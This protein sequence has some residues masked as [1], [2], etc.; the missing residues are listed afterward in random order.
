MSGLYNQGSIQGE[1]DTTMRDLLAVV[2]KRK[3]L[4]ITFFV[5]TSGIVVLKVMTTPKTWSAD[6]TL[7]LQRQGRTSVMER[8]SRALPWVEV[9]E[10]EVAIAKSVPVL[11]LAVVKLK[12][13]TKDFPEGIDVSVGSLDN[14]VSTGGVG[15]SNVIYI[16]STADAPKKA[17]RIANMVGQAYVE[18]HKEMFALPDASGIVKRQADSAL[19]VLRDLQ[20][21]RELV[22]KEA[23]FTD[24]KGEELGLQSLRRVL[25]RQLSDAQL[26]ATRL[27]AQVEAIPTSVDG[28]E[29]SL[30]FS[31]PRG[32]AQ[33]EVMLTALTNYRKKEHQLN[34]LRIQFTET[35]PRVKKAEA[36]LAEL[37]QELQEAINQLVS[38]KRNEL[39]VAE[40]EV[41]GIRKQIVEIEGSLAELPTYMN[42]VEVL[43]T[44]ISSMQKQYATLTE[45]YADT[46]MS[47][48]SFQNYGVS[49]LSPAI[50]AY[51]NAKGDLVRMALAP[52]LSL[53]AGI[54][55]AFYLENL[56][57]SMKTRED[58]EQHLEIPV[59]ASF[60]DVDETES[61]LEPKARR[62]PFWRGR[63]G[64]R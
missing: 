38:L 42:E 47:Q 26:K 1:R 4:I 50:A 7:M 44:Q 10:S 8:S 27:R 53:L 6:A 32:N 37:K 60:P 13:P 64:G 25:K 15:E 35:H 9:I 12:E 16:T 33:P 17:I 39:A 51:V 18:Y 56:D 22:L 36:E 58:V 45:K 31:L 20:N 2:F 48:I 63:H 52:L 55:L 62:T 29:S 41:D 21:R 23:G 11:Q 54:G 57:H 40:A 34:E 28:I 14:S 46:R 43:D 59:L 49:M 24:L 3:W 30:P 61:D 19:T 5:V